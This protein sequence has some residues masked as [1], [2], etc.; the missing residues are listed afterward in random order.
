[1]TDT[2]T[3]ALL[4]ELDRKRAETEKFVAEQRKL[5]AEAEKFADEQRK[6]A[7]EAQKFDRERRLLPWS[8]LIALTTGIGIG[9]VQLIAHH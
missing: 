4:I 5:I 3:Q 6:L 1:M 7:A 2:G 8:L 9:L